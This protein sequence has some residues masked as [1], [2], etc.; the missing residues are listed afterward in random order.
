MHIGH[1]QGSRTEFAEL[2]TTLIKRRRVLRW[3]SLVV[4]RVRVKATPSTAHIPLLRQAPQALE[5]LVRAGILKE[6]IHT[7]A[8][9]LRARKRSCRLAPPPKQKQPTKRKPLD[10]PHSRRRRRSPW[11]NRRRAHTTPYSREKSSSQGYFTSVRVV[12]CNAPWA[13][14]IHGA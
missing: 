12:V 1:Y 13:R 4:V 5:I 3:C 14:G 6:R 2:R 10:Q 9:A 7:Q 11:G 8:A